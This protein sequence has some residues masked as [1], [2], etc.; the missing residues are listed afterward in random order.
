MTREYKYDGETFVLDDAKGC[1]I[2][3]TYKDQVG[4]VGVNLQGT[5]E[6]PYLWWPEQ[7]RWV[8]SD[9]LTNGNSSGGD[10]ASNLRAMCRDLLSRHRQEEARK[11]FR[12]KEACKSL[13]EFAQSLPD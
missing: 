8:T 11:A 4:Y 13:H 12:P 3:A 2:E 6:A 10:L 5:A 1:Y 7:S 9:G